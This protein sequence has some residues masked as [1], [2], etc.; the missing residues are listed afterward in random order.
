MTR[1]VAI[2]ANNTN[3]KLK[4]NISL[5]NIS[6]LKSFFDLIIIDSADEYYANL[7]YEDLHS[8]IDN[9]YLM[10][11]DFCLYFGKWIL[12]LSKI[13]LDQYDGFLFIN[14][15]ILLVDEIKS[16][17]DLLNDN[18]HCNLYAYNDSYQIKY[19]Y[20]THL[21]YIKRNLIPKF[22]EFFESKK[23]SVIDIKTF[24]ENPIFPL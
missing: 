21:F 18:L 12:G 23:D 10:K 16:Y 19:Y 6:F 22:I 4:Y 5:H 13:N 9:F 14:D 3:S 2:L 24:V 1:I 20:Q 8:I 7:L 17:F 15:S 11:N